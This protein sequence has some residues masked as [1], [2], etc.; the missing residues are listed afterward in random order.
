MYSRILLNYRIGRELM[1][2]LSTYEDGFLT[3]EKCDVYEPIRHKFNPH[4]FSEVLTW[5]NR[6]NNMGITFKRSKPIRYELSVEDY[7]K[8]PR[9]IK[10]ELNYSL[11]L[12][13][14]KLKSEEFVIDF[15][16]KLFAILKA[17]FGF[18]TLSKD[19][20][21]K[22]HLVVEEEGY[23]KESYVGQT[24]EKEG[25]PGLYWVNIFSKSY[26]EWFGKSKFDKLKCWRKEELPDGS[27]LVQFC[28]KPEDS[29]SESTL[30][31]QEIVK[32]ILGNDVFFDIHKLNK[33][34]KIPKFLT[35]K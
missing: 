14:T 7:S 17:D 5:F 34:I 4:D 1:L 35:V 18:L 2:F 26:V 19:Y 16:K 9:N 20:D 22:N 23:I 25:L 28:E 13:V 12:K 3:P 27:I 15:F 11:D 8:T 29:L 32:K 24:L 33:H 30:K 21:L 6:L 31:S 10:S